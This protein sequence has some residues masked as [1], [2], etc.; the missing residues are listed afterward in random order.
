VER[1][2]AVLSVYDLLGYVLVG[3]L[4]VAGCYWAVE[5]VPAEPGVATVLGL[6]AFSYIVGHL[7]QS[8]STFWERLV[9]RAGWPAELRLRP[10]H[11]KAYDNRLRGLVAA[12]LGPDASALRLRDQ[13][14]F[15]RAMLRARGA[16]AQPELMNVAYGFCRGLTTSSALL[17]VVFVVAAIVS[18]RSRPLGIAAGLAAAAA[19]LLFVRCR[20]FG[21]R[22]ADQVWRDLVALPTANKS[23]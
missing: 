16:D 6:V 3:G 17:A 23:A 21:F 14:A 22:F 13:F 2:I 15:A 18:D 11:A 7:V 1:I 9:W 8:V 4:L 19:A 20:R 5:G 10:G 12:R